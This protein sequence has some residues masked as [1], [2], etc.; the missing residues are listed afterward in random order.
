MYFTQRNGSKTSRLQL[1]GLALIAYATMSNHSFAQS[2]RPEY[3]LSCV[4]S[5]AFPWGQA[6]ERWVELIKEKTQGRINVRLYAGASLVGGDQTRE[7]PALQQGVID[8]AVSSTINWSP[9]VKEL[10]LFSLPFLLPD[11]KAIDALTQGEVGQAIFQQITQKG[12]V[13]LAWG[14]NGFRELTNSR[15]SI[16]SPSD[17]KG[18]KF[19]VVGSPIFADIFKSL[20]ATPVLMSWVDAQPALASGIVDGQENPISVYTAANMIYLG[21]RHMSLWHYVA[22]PLLFAVNQQ[23][24]STWSPQDRELVRQA[25]QQAARENIE[26][27]RKGITKG[28]AATL[29]RIELAGGTITNITDEQR[30]TFVLATRSV[31]KKWAETIGL[32]LV[33]M[34]EKAIAQR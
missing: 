11:H 1:L 15:R 7:F 33:N 34:A 20:N 19:R 24:W 31:Y 17:M 2:Y 29:K 27:A 3:R 8:L 23:V 30:A 25:A 4:L 22:D 16:T 13:P 21:Q 18:M 32:P 14:E 6:G 26:K 5:T 10:N 12:V 28:D 9:Q